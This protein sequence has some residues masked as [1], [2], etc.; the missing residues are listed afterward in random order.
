MNAA[1]AAKAP[2]LRKAAFDIA[3][4]IL[5]ALAGKGGRPWR[6]YLLRQSHVT[7]W[8]ISADF[9]I[10]A[11]LRPYDCFAFSFFPYDAEI[12]ALLRD[13]SSGLQRDLKDISALTAAEIAWLR[14]RRR[15]HI[16]IAV[17]RKR[18]AF[19]VQGASIELGRRLVADWLAEMNSAPNS[20]DQSRMK[21]LRNKVRANY[22][23]RLLGNVWLL[24]VL[25]GA[26]TTALALGRP[27]EVVGWFPDRDNMTNWS[28]GVWFDAVW[29]TTGFL[30]DAFRIDMRSL[31]TVSGV[32]AKQD[33][34]EHMWFDSLIRGPDFLAG[35]IAAWDRSAR[36]VPGEKYR[37]LLLDVVADSKNIIVMDALL[38]P[39]TR[40]VSRVLVS[41]SP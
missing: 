38:G 37:Q 2:E 24:S 17:N 3:N 35:V 14:D 12:E 19:P 18:P 23:A 15:F 6:R 28:E 1:V 26:L 16:A 32:P 10:G 30:A 33:G 36:T 31:K 22:N 13:A 8:T 39:G 20:P 40:A 25:F 21:A 29:R 27:L 7:K 41:R 4:Q 11:E 5:G 34:Q 9:C